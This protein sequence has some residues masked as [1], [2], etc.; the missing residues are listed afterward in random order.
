MKAYQRNVLLKWL[1][2]LIVVVPVVS[3]CQLE[4]GISITGKATCNGRAVP[5]SKMS[6]NH[7]IGF[8]VNQI[9]ETFTDENGDFSVSGSALDTSRNSASRGLRVAGFIEIMFEFDFFEPGD[10]RR[11]FGVG[12][13][14]AIPVQQFEGNV[15]LGIVE[16]DSASCERYLMF[17]DV[18]QDYKQRGGVEK[19]EFFVVA[20]E[21][22]SSRVP[23]AYM[24]HVRVPE[25]FELTREIAKHEYG[26]VIRN[27][28]DGDE[29]HFK[30]DVEKYGGT[31]AHT[32]DTETSEQFAFN[33]GWA[34]Y[35]AAQC[36]VSDANGSK[37]IEGNVACALR[38]MQVRCASNDKQ[39]LEVLV[40][41]RGRIH[42]YE[43]FAQAH[44]LLYNCS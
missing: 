5:H 2:V 32:C 37:C 20:E 14:K 21:R 26:H 23:Y 9:G 40:Q 3:Q 30:E 43:E 44:Q 11:T 1:L 7:I 24:T 4:E 6:L 27:Y 42:S 28:F 34:Y 35:W 19:I 18:V 22:I 39:M 17:Y 12:Q 36:L 41:N 29:A 25:G 10:S 15:D 38:A 8:V 33:E 16:A 31:E 13:W